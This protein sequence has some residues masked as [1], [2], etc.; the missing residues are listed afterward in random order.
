V[1]HLFFLFAIV[2][3]T[4][5]PAS[6][7]AIVDPLTPVFPNLQNE[8]LYD[9]ET[10]QALRDVLVDVSWKQAELGQV[11]RDLTLAVRTARPIAAD[12]NFYLSSSAPPDF[13][14]RRITI[15]TKR[16]PVFDVLGQ[17]AEQAGFTIKVHAGVVL[18][19]P[20]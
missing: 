11:L 14:Q 10:Y 4:C 8:P 7:T 20:R 16:E 13:R 12:I 18:I 2:F 15:M 19:V 6:V 5:A 3:T 1:R 17:M 9:Q